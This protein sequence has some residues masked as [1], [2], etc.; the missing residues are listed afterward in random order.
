E[1]VRI[2]KEMGVDAYRFSISWSRILP[3]G[4]LIGGVN[5]AGVNFYKELIKELT[6][7]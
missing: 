1:D 6:D 5:E 2:M 7:N 4:K 3:T